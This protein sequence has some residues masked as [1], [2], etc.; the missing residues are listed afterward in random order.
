MV[1]SGGIAPPARGCPST[2][3]CPRQRARA[4]QCRSASGEWSRAYGFL[5]QYIQLSNYLLAHF[6]GLVLG[7]IEAKFSQ[8]NTRWKALDE[9]YRIFIPVHLRNPLQKPRISPTSKSQQIF[10][11]SFCDFSQ[12]FKQIG[13]HFAVFVP[14]CN[15]VLQF[16]SRF[17]QKLD[18]LLL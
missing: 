5:T 1:V 3:A 13:R 17:G 8:P 10:V 14:M 9:I 11:T 16:P 12:C 2:P 7:C 4:W 18:E 6:R 15:A